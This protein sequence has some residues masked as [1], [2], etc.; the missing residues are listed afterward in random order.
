MELDIKIETF[1]PCQEAP[2]TDYADFALRESI[3]GLVAYGEFNL[4]TCGVTPVPTDDSGVEGPEFYHIY[5]GGECVIIY[6]TCRVLV[7]SNERRAFKF[8]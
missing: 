8:I 2:S 4:P 3:S 6:E 7:T 1:Y 5:H